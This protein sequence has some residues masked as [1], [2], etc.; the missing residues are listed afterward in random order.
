MKRFISL[1]VALALIMS[2]VPAAFAAGEPGGAESEAAP[3]AVGDDS[4]FAEVTT[5]GENVTELP[6]SYSDR[7][8]TTSSYELNEELAALSSYA[9]MRSMSSSRSQY[10]VRATDRSSPAT[11][12][13]VKTASIRASRQHATRS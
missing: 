11:L 2:S 9:A 1:I 5:V 7:W 6:Y 13:S 12:Q 3:A 4:R 8:F 10:T